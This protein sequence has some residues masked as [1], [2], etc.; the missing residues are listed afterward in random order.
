MLRL[1][2][3]VAASDHSFNMAYVSPDGVKVDPK[4]KLHRLKTLMAEMCEIEESQDSVCSDLGND[5]VL[6]CTEN[7]YACSILKNNDQGDL[8][9]RESLHR[10]GQLVLTQE[11][12]LLR[13]PGPY[14]D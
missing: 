14:A 11:I 10:F 5:L 4:S 9:T 8:C 2:K 6:D 3:Y 7:I 12:L 13:M 1:L